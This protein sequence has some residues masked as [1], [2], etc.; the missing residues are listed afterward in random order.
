MVCNIVLCIV[1]S[2]PLDFGI[3]YPYMYRFGIFCN[4]WI[5][6]LSKVLSMIGIEIFPPEFT[7]VYTVLVVNIEEIYWS[8]CATCLLSAEPPRSFATLLNRYRGNIYSNKGKVFW[9]IQVPLS[10]FPGRGGSNSWIISVIWFL[11]SLLI[12]LWTMDSFLSCNLSPILCI[13][14]SPI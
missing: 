11:I 13:C 14:G 6:L 2:E 4:I 8:I 1:A 9:C 7:S 12:L 3:E 10:N 5:Y